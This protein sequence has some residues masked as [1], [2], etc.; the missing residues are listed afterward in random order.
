MGTTSI[1]SH[2]SRLRHLAA[3]LVVLGLAAAG[4]VP[5]RAQAQIGGALPSLSVPPSLPAPINPPALTPLAPMTAPAL[6]PAAPTP[7]AATPAP[8][9]ARA[10]PA[11]R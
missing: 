8:A 6:T 4:A 1:M 5:A 7:Q 9:A 2:P 10:Q 11:Q 3:G